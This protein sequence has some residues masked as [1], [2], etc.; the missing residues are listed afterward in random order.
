MIRAVIRLSRRHRLWLALA[1]GV[2]WASGALWLLYHN[3]FRVEGDFGP[4]PHGLEK[5]WLRLHGL[6]AMLGLFVLGTMLPIHMKLAWRRNKNRRMGALLSALLLWLAATGY[7]LWYFA[8]ES[9]EAWLPLLHW[10]AGLG[11]PLLLFIHIHAGRPRPQ[12]HLT[13]KEPLC[14][15]SSS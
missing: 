1:L 7:A 10:A 15:P 2:L 13:K 5:W 11:L 9:V 12:V 8:G 3:F 14:F 6:S 4:Q